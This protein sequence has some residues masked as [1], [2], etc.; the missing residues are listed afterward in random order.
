MFK[1]KNMYLKFAGLVLIGVAFS[2][3]I[4]AIIRKYIPQLA[5]ILDRGE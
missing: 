3:K 1:N 2:G 5:D 4:K